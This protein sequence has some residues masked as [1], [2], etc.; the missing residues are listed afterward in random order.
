MKHFILNFD[1]ESA[2]NA[3]SKISNKIDSII[4]KVEDADNSLV[5]I[6][7]YIT[8]LDDL[9]KLVVNKIETL[10]IPSSISGSRDKPDVL[11]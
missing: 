5:D 10:N 9:E 3:L 2:E 1:P 7:N 11:N 4:D 6:S 8:K